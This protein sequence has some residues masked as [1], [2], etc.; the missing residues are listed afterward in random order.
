MQYW[1]KKATGAGLLSHGPCTLDEMRKLYRQGL[2]GRTQQVSIDGGESWRSAGEFPEVFQRP[3]LA[4]PPPPPP[5]PPQPLI[6]EDEWGIDVGT[7]G[8]AGW[9][10]PPS[11]GPQSGPVINISQAA[12]QGQQTNGMAIAGFVLSLLG[13]GCITALLGFIF[14]LVALNS[15]NRANR[16][17]AIAGAIIG[18]LWLLGWVIYFVLVM[19]LAAAQAPL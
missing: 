4:P 8:P 14:S 7:A 2:L 16:G 3:A 9:P 11:D 18:G 15:S 19:I 17:L 13:C 12:P 1:Y 6:E 5:P 10:P